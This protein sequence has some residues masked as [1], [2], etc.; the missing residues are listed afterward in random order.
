M[1]LPSIGQRI[2]YIGDEARYALLARN[3]LVTGD[4]LV[5][6]LD[7][8]VHMEKSPLFMWA[9]A[10]LSLP[11]GHVTELT[12]T[13]PAALSGIAGVGATL[14]LGR[15]LF[16]SRA[17]LLAAFVL[18]TTWGYYWHARLV[19]ADMMVTC[20]V[21]AGAIGF[22]AGAG[23]GPSRRWPLALFWACI[24]LGFSAKGPVGLMPIIPFAAFLVVEHGWRGLRT[25]RPLMGAAIVALI[26]AP[27]ALAFALQGEESYVRSVLVEDFLG[28]R[29]RL[30]DRPSEVF[31]ALGPIGVGFLPWTPFLPAAVR[32]GWGRAE[33]ADVG[34]A[35]RFLGY[36]ALA[37]IIVITLMPH[38]RDR[39]LLPVHPALALMVGWLWD[40]W[41]TRAAPGALRDHAWVW[42][43]LVAAMGIAV[44]LPLHPRPELAVLIPPA[45]GQRL[46][47]SGL[48]LAAGGVA[49]AA[50]RAGR[51]LAVF[52]T[53]CAS[54][55]LVLA[56]E[57][58][59]FVAGHNLA[60]DVKAL[61]RRLVSQV[62]PRDQLVTYQFG[63]LALEFYTGRTIREVGSAR[64]L[65][66]FLSTGRPL[67]VVVSE[68]SWRGLRDATGREWTV[69]DRADL[70]GRLMLV[71][72]PAVPG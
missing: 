48:L 9:I 13:L 55:A 51:P 47:L 36:W 24:G 1:F 39:Y 44:L 14:L 27:W 40:R 7:G 8:E 20:F 12:A 71:V 22:W 70:G 50:A 2:I 19:L 10:A 6:R 65:E 15:R 3:M 11:G 38:K 26:S 52:A 16:G 41:A 30:W 68:R 42:G 4:W 34:R 63:E 61:S 5:P 56:Y 58:Q 18:A 31:F 72:T 53:V 46:L 29:L 25:L 64:D 57:T 60:F 28:P 35:F 49:V 59:V 21:V 66:A 17:G 45:L 62:G 23:R 43:S 54:T 69:V 32:N 37:Y 33:H 67:Y